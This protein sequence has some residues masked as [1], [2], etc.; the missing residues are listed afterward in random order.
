MFRYNL[1]GKAEILSH[2]DVKKG[3]RILE[4]NTLKKQNLPVESTKNMKMKKHISEKVFQM[5][6]SELKRK[7]QKKIRKFKKHY[8]M[9]KS[10][11][12]GLER[13]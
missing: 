5:Y 1:L 8:E 11:K 13:V 7:E 12:K 9:S 10:S 2:L 4:N 6:I 3:I